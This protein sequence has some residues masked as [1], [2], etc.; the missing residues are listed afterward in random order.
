MRFESERFKVWSELRR[1]EKMMDEKKKKSR[2]GFLR[3]T[4]NVAAMPF[5]AH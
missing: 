3:V 1:T 4:R 2:L 5:C